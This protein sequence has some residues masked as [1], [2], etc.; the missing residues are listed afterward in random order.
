MQ[1]N[2]NFTT[3]L[4]KKKINVRTKVIGNICTILEELKSDVFVYLP[5]KTIIAP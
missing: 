2:S 5:K 4:S 1:N 3:L